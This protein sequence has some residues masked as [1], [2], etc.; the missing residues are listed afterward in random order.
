MA[1]D[2]RQR[3]ADA[4]ALSP[5]QPLV[6]MA[7]GEV[8][9][10]AGPAV[11]EAVFRNGSITVVGVIAGFSL[12]FLTAWGANPLPWGLKDLF[13]LVPIVLGVV[14]QL[15]SLA[16]LLDH[17][18]LELPRYTRARHLFMIGLVLVAIGVA[19]ALAVDVWAVSQGSHVIEAPE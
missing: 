14:F 18:S 1:E 2:Y 10:K 19:T 7:Q 3:T 8:L 6:T 11:I 9:P 12:G 4:Q 5:V 13:A 17:R 15:I 16:L